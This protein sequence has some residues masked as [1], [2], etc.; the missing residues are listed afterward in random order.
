MAK[1]KIIEQ[2]IDK[3]NKKACDYCNKLCV[4]SSKSDKYYSYFDDFI[5]LLDSNNS[6]IRNRAFSL[7]CAQARWDA[8]KKIDKALKK[9]FILFHDEKPITV[10]QSLKAIQEV[11][12]FKPELNHTIKKELDTIDLGKYKDSMAPLI[13]KDI[14]EIKRMID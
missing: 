9:M 11:I 13:K 5:E 3:D 1:N 4:E 10:R 14:D 12:I 2:L 8:D 7:C 6:Y